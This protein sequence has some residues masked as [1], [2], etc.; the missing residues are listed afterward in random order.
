MNLNVLGLKEK[1]R[2]VTED[3]EHSSH[4]VAEVNFVF[5]DSLKS[6]NEI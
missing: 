6:S 2:N 1:E 3:V 4:R 5:D